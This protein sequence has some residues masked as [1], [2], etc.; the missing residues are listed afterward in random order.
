MNKIPIH[1]YT[2]LVFN[3]KYEKPWYLG[4]S[5]WQDQ[6]VHPNGVFYPMGLMEIKAGQYQV[7]QGARIHESCAQWAAEACNKKSIW[8]PQHHYRCPRRR[9]W[10]ARQQSGAEMQTPARILTPQTLARMLNRAQQRKATGA[11]LRCAIYANF[12]GILKYDCRSQG[13][14]KYSMSPANFKMSSS[15]SAS[16][17]AHAPSERDDHYKHEFN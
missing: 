4:W 8:I 5:T 11:R 12:P 9:S 10:G 6:P 3:L 2:L 17:V 7:S 15:V 14:K 16:R 13:L 1:K